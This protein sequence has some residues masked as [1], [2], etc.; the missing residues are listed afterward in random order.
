MRLSRIGCCRT[1]KFSRRK[2]T[3]EDRIK[4]RTISRAQRSAGTRCSA[5]WPPAFACHQQT[6]TT[7]ARNHAGTTGVWWEP[8]PARNHAGTTRADLESPAARNHAEHDARSAPRAFV[9][10]RHNGRAAQR[11]IVPRL[12]N[13]RSAQ[14]AP[15]QRTVKIAAD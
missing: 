4:N 1:V 14:R 11:A 6:P 12:H 9:P 13:A 3:T 8:H 15:A 2:R 10:H 7:S 5:G